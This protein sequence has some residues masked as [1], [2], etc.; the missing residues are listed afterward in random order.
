MLHLHFYE[1][2]WFLFLTNKMGIKLKYF[3]YRFL[4][5]ILFLYNMIESRYYFN[6]SSTNSKE[7]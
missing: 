2:S 1:F 4:C 5:H 3:I 6:V 7:C